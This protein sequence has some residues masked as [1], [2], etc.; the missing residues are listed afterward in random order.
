MAYNPGEAITYD[1]IDAALPPI[2]MDVLRGR[3]IALLTPIADRARYDTD[4]MTKIV[5]AVDA[6]W[7]YYADLTG[8][9]PTI[10]P[11]KSI[12]GLGAVAV[13]PSTCDAGCGFLGFT[14]IEII[15][16]P[17][18]DVWMHDSVLQ[19]DEYD[20]IAFS[21]L[22]RNFWFYGTQLGAQTGTDA[23]NGFAVASRFFSMEAAGV[24]GAPFNDTLPFKDFQNSIMDDMSWAYFEDDSL[25]W[26]NTIL[27]GVAPTN[28]FGFSSADLLASLYGR[29]HEDFG[30][31][32]YSQMWQ[33]I[34]NGPSATDAEQAT[35]NFIDAATEVTGIDYSFLLKRGGETFVVGDEEFL[36]GSAPDTLHLPTE[37]EASNAVAHGFGGDDLI[38]GRDGDDL[39]FGGSGDDMLRGRQGSDTL[40]GG[41]GDDTLF[42]GGWKDRLFGGTGDDLLFGRGGKDVLVGGSGSDV[43][44]GDKGNDL[45]I[46]GAGEKDR[47]HGG[48]GADVF[49]FG[50]EL[51]NGVRE[52]DLIMDYQ[53]GIDMLDLGDSD[54]FYFTEFSGAVLIDIATPTVEEEDEIWVYGISSAD[55]IT[56]VTDDIA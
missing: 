18:F 47:L 5:S 45:I 40:V 2:D 26:D 52:V 23:A 13:V 42:G 39:M 56:F 16:D 50:S 35:A 48:E 22:G 49:I 19:D 34:G 32:A 54:N 37:A 15:G 31:E 28:R 9:L 1:P 51:D 24:D 44:F 27:T 29:I 46:G 36:S 20:H 7:D 8:R 4:T 55:Q 43:L 38:Q 30:N 14:G 53:P 21:E 33:T 11:S 17:Y 6:G 41:E 25:S 12:D 3:N 10:Q